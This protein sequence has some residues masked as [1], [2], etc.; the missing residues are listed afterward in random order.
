MSLTLEQPIKLTGAA[1]QPINYYAVPDTT[2]GRTNYTVKFNVIVD[3]AI[4]ATYKATLN[5]DSK[6]KVDVSKALQTVLSD[7]IP[8]GTETAI[9]SALNSIVSY[10]VTAFEYWDVDGIL[11]LQSGSVTSDEHWAIP[12]AYIPTNSNEF[13]TDIT[14]IY[15][16]GY[17]YLG[18]LTDETM[19]IYAK[20]NGATT[21]PL[22]S[23][24]TINKL[25]LIPINS[26]NM[27][28]NTILS[29]VV[30]DSEDNAISETYIIDVYS[31]CYSDPTT[32]LFRNKYGVMESYT[33]VNKAR[34]LKATREAALYGNDWSNHGV[35]IDKM[36]VLYGKYESD[37]TRL[38]LAQLFK[39]RVTCVDGEVIRVDS[40]NYFDIDADLWKPIIEIQE[41][42]DYLN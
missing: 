22:G 24:E 31:V 36:V 2:T 20:I 8:T 42:D 41:A 1:Y 28:G 10:T 12:A 30:Y 9:I 13:L 16:N 3:S 17:M 26:T 29:V 6:F 4:I 33:F 5:S 39:S 27:G 23:G 40:D 15:K 7:D 19:G 14:Y 37:S 25:A 34:E 38:W 35:N 18:F 32:V 11:T 21:I